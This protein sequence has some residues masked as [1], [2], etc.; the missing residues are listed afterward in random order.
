[1]TFRRV[2]LIV[3]VAALALSGCTPTAPEVEPSASAPE[4]APAETGADA[5][6]FCGVYPEAYIDIQTAA[7][8][9]GDGGAVADVSTQVTV[10][11]DSL[12]LA[13]TGV[14]AGD[15]W[16]DFIATQKGYLDDVDAAVA[17]DD[18]MTL[19]QTIVDGPS[20]IEQLT[21]VC[22]GQPGF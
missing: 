10:A 14:L 1:M 2:S 22:A 6:E 15:E 18:T 13:S 7:I 19:L 12:E 4:A 20:P 16:A 3:V 8:A 11:R 5:T 17:A 9:I 21:E